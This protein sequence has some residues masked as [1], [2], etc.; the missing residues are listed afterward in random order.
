MPKS[1]AALLPDNKPCCTFVELLVSIVQTLALLDRLTEHR[2][3]FL[4]FLVVRAIRA[5]FGFK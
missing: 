5:E 1:Y 3:R 2:G 4:G